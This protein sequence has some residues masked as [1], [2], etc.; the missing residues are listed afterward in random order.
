[1]PTTSV[2]QDRLLC[3]PLW[4][5]AERRSREWAERF[6]LA[7]GAGTQEQLERVA[8]GRMAGYICPAG[9]LGSLDLIAQWGVLTFA[10]DDEFDGDPQS[11]DPE[12]ARSRLDQLLAVMRYD[13][14]E[15]DLSVPAVRAMSD[16]WS[17]MT[18]GMRLTWADRFILHYSQFA[19]A[20]C[21][22]LGHRKDGTRPSL[23]EYL[24]MRRHSITVMPM[25]DVAERS[26]SEEFPELDG[27][28]D[29]VADTIGWA[30]DL[31]SVARDVDEGHE[32]LV[33]VLAR[34]H[35]CSLR[36]ASA[37][38]RTMIRERMD[39]FDRQASGLLA[40]GPSR[41]QL[42]C[43]IELLRTVRDGMLAWQSESGR[44]PCEAVGDDTPVR[45]GTGPARRA[46]DRL[47]G[48]LAAS[49]TATG[50]LPDRC[51]SRVLESALMLA[52]LRRTGSH[53]RHQDDLV[54]FLHERRADAD[55]LE[56][57]LIDACF[58][59]GERMAGRVA[60]VVAGLSEGL[61][62]FTGRRGH[63]KRLMVEVV[64]HLLCGT[65][66][67]G[68]GVPAQ[69]WEGERST[70]TDA[71]LLAVKILHAGA[72]G[73]HHRVSGE[74][75]ARL[76]NLLRSGQGRR[77]YEGTTIAHLLALFAVLYENRG[78]PVIGDGITGALAAQ[79]ED[80]GMPALDSEDIWLVAIASLAFLAHDDLRPLVP[81]MCGF[82]AAEQ[83]ADGGWPFATGMQQTDVDTTIRCIEILR[84]ADPHKYAAHIA[85]ALAYLADMAGPDGGF[86]TWVRGDTSD[87]DMTAGAV[88]AMAP[89]H[90]KHPGVLDAAVEFILDVQK[91]DGSFTPSWSISESSAILRAVDALRT[92]NDVRTDHDPALRARTVEAVARATAHLEATQ[93]PDGG[94]G[95]GGGQDSDVLSTAQAL[96]VVARH[97]DPRAARAAVAYLLSRQDDD[98][99]FTSIPDQVGPR[100]L[101]FDFPANA[102]ICTLGALTAAIEALP[103][104]DHRLWLNDP[105]RTAPATTAAP[106]TGVDWSI[107]SAALTGE[108]ITPH[109][110]GYHE[111]RQILNPRFDHIQPQAVARVADQDDV[112]AC[113]D[114]A[115][116]HGISLTTRCGGHSY[117]GYSTNPGLVIDVRAL[118]TVQLGEGTVRAGSGLMTAELDQALS[119][120]GRAV[121]LAGCPTVG[122][123]GSTLGGGVSVFSRTWGL[124]C[125][126]LTGVDIVTADGALRQ[127]TDA[128]DDPDADLFWALRGGGGGNFGVVTALE[129]STVDIT[130]LTFTS[131]VA[132]WPFHLA[133]DLVRGWQNWVADPATPDALFTIVVLAA[134]T[135][136]LTSTVT[137]TLIGTPEQARTLLASLVRHVGH[138]YD[139]STITPTTPTSAGILNSV[140][141]LGLSKAPPAPFEAESPTRFPPFAAKSHLVYEPLTDAAI[142][143]M[144]SD[145][146]LLREIGGTAA[147]MMDTMAGKV[148]EIEP[149]TSAY[150]HRSA[151]AMIQ[152]FSI[153]SKDCTRTQ[154][155][156]RRQWLRTIH[157]AVGEHVGRGAYVN[158]IDPELDN[159]QDAYYGNNYPRLREVKAAYDPHRLFDFP[160]A[161][162]SAPHSARPAAAA[163]QQPQAT[164]AA[165]SQKPATTSFPRQRFHELREQDSPVDPAELDAIWA[166]LD[167]VRI[168]E[169]LGEWNGEV[170]DTGH[171]GALVTQAVGWR[172]KNFHSAQNV[173]P[174]VLHGL[175]GISRIEAA[176]SD[177]SLWMVEF[178]SEVT[179]AMV[180]DH[181]PVIDH[182][183]KVDNDTLMGVMGGKDIVLDQ[184]H[185]LY[186]SL[187]RHPEHRSGR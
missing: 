178:R 53:Q 91:P 153:W 180:Y 34:E 110:P 4:L 67:T 80:G 1:M 54:R 31:Q 69:A 38:A 70:I 92:V 117:A 163:P 50:N 154:I 90:H 181:V 167:T 186:F 138:P 19:E 106:R 165:D 87:L 57:V 2:A 149:H 98:G 168:K 109:D 73:R 97:G 161:I 144:V 64:F 6:G 121:P 36:E 26:C 129:Y 23:A 179:A 131:I 14:R 42:A 101:P 15:T 99:G 135:G 52:L 142:D 171:R 22:E 172:G 51:H 10:V 7:A 40:G 13:A 30:N 157:T 145:F 177:A 58:E 103:D 100:P 139:H 151:I 18:T 11:A 75:R 136:H 44:Y 122:I 148:A 137:G 162:E 95:H 25:L 112:V 78:H 82:L 9:D 164:G 187:K 155:D 41:S 46:A 63:L 89:A 29:A 143:A 133:T 28:R 74:E 116:E 60:D 124:S 49:V 105:L 114:F 12:V 48:R 66:V 182:F 77:T 68:D 127:V 152:Y 5:R 61:G 76:V 170:F 159:W 96:S 119:A 108:V 62:Q 175:E 43:R 118:K 113:V 158:C 130:S 17:R 3:S 32:N 141:P 173:K 183:K 134:D 47:A 169:I 37:M 59:P 93:N 126:R 85:A 102:N 104:I 65:P 33:T 83:A 39:D 84:A 146:E 71:H 184:G 27:V 55:P 132:K 120:A 128:P 174:V 176:P 35:R 20:T 115:R 147:V 16:L 94:W 160:R 81:R 88:I 166:A 125:D 111:I 150:P 45:F 140:E 185:H 86:P 156:R 107:L 24:E 123:A 21:R 8:A 56:T 79:N 72:T